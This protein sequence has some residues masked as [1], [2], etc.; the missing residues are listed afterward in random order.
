MKLRPKQSAAQTE[1]PLGFEAGSDLAANRV[2]VDAETGKATGGVR[3]SNDLAKLGSGTHKVAIDVQYRMPN[4]SPGSLRA[5]RI[6]QVVHGKLDHDSLGRV[7]HGMVREVYDTLRDQGPA[8]LF[9]EIE[10][11]D[12]DDEGEEDEE[13]ELSREYYDEDDLPDVDSGGGDT[14]K[15]VFVTSISVT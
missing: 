5:T 1:L 3:L 13:G 15:E 9:S 2:Y 8:A 10:T 4:D 7:V 6:T 12:D 14:P 11:G